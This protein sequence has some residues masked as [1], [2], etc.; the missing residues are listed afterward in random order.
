MNNV[1]YIN[2]GAGAGKT[3]TLVTILKEILTAKN[4]NGEY[5]C[6]PSEVI[7]TTYTK[8]AAKEFRKKTFERLLKAPADINVAKIL[9]TATIGTVHSV[10]E[11]YIKR[12]WSLLGYS[13]LF[14]VMSETDKKRYI[15]QSLKNFVTPDDLE[16]FYEYTQEFKLTKYD[17]AKG[18]HISY[19]DFW[20]DYVLE[21]VGKMRAYDIKATDIKRFCVQSCEVADRLFSTSFDITKLQTNAA[22][23]IAKLNTD[24]LKVK[25]DKTPTESAKDAQKKLD[26]FNLFPATPTAA[27]ISQFLE[28]DFFPKTVPQDE[29][30][31][32]SVV[33][34]KQYL[35]LFLFLTPANCA[36]VKQCIERIFSIAEKWHQEYE[37]YKRQNNLLDFEDL[38]AKFL[39]LLKMQAVRDDIRSSVK[40]MFVDEFQDSNPIQLEI[41]KE[42]SD[43]V[44]IKSFWVGDRKQAIYGFRG[45]DSSLITNLLNTHF[46]TLGSAADRFVPGLTSELIDTSYRS[47]KSL[48]ELSNAVFEKSFSVGVPSEIINNVPLQPHR[49]QPGKDDGNIQ[50]PIQHWHCPSE[51]AL[52]DKVA[53][54]LYGAATEFPGIYYDDDDKWRKAIVPSDIAIL[55]RTGAE[56]DKMAEALRRK[57][58]PVSSPET[59]IL[60]KAE[61]KLVFALLKYVGSIKRR[62]A[63]MELAKLLEEIT[64]NETLEDKTTITKTVSKTIGTIL[65]EIAANRYDYNPCFDEENEADE[66]VGAAGDSET[67]GSSKSEKVKRDPDNFFTDISDKLQGLRG[68][69]I[70]AIV[71]GVIAVMDVRNIVAKWGNAA[72]RQDNLDT[73]IEQAIAFEQSAANSTKSATVADFLRHMEEV[74]LESELDQ[75]AEG[76]KVATYHKS[77]GL[78][79]PIVILNS[80]DNDELGI[81]D[82]VKRNWFGL[83]LKGN[84][85]SAELQ[86]IPQCINVDDTVAEAVKDLSMAGAGKD[87][88]GYYDMRFGK[89]EGELKRL[90]YVGVTRAKDYLV[91]LSMKKSP[92]K[93]MGNVIGEHYSPAL[94][95]IDTQ[96]DSTTVDLWSFTP[97]ATS[98]EKPTVAPNVFYMQIPI[99]TSTYTTTATTPQ[100]LKAGYQLDST[101]EHKTISPSSSEAKYNATAKPID[102]KDFKSGGITHGTVKDGEYDEFGTCIHNYFAVHQWTGKGDIDQNK[103]ANKALAAATVAN[104]GK[105]KEL[106]NPETMTAAADTLFAYLEDKFGVGELLRECPFTYCRDN[107]QLVHGEIDLVWKNDNNCILVDYKNYPGTVDEITKEGGNFN[108]KKYFPQLGDY[109]TA[110]EATGMKVTKVY[111]FYAVL[112]CLVEV[113]IL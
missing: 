104:H 53:N 1:H 3:Y 48:V 42:L 76:V 35:N 8:A 13:G 33:L 67:D 65:Q 69:N 95:T 108:V 54:I 6:L 45:S 36:M 9:D 98:T 87:D 25:K 99:G 2:A 56:C 11:Q 77:K 103:A 101:T 62:Y 113:E 79:W 86:L 16:F 5:T 21:I 29:P 94:D 97:P 59:S 26:S 39:E 85:G 10:A 17:S 107:G 82:F 66:A 27:E 74:E 93:W 34:S 89:V 51:D 109:K 106:P 63:K 32:S 38:E 30:L 46:A 102:K 100:K 7:L 14:N 61:V 23:Y 71:K 22:A 28:S 24:S 75:S 81:K 47:L 57:G 91:T 68:L 73:L 37:D 15:N 43:L 44:Q 50:N 41:F 58:I 19:Y 90:L 80:L 72:I 18:R 20:K 64:V 83:N 31:K 60:D 12:Y 112:G 105:K 92:L 96:R 88:N 70:S 55:S 52:A 110:L 111:V 40:Y 78:Q 4:A 84:Y 49:V